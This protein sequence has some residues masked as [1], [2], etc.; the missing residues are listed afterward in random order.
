M[1]LRRALRSPVLVLL[2]GTALAALSRAADPAAQGEA[3]FGESSELT[4]GLPAGAEVSLSL[5][6][7]SVVVDLPDGATYPTD[8]SNASN[9]LLRSAEVSK[10]VRGRVRLE[11]RLA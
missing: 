8:F 4:V 2:L 10:P 1:A 3:H 7:G 5:G 11:L 6:D 9:G